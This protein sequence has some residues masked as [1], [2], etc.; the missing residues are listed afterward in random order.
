[1]KLIFL[2]LL[3][4]TSAAAMAQH[5]VSKFTPAECA[6]LQAFILAQT[7]RIILGKPTQ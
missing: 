3:I 1:M 7:S 4:A 6:A 2:L 5:S